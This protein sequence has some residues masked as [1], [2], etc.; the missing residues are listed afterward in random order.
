[1]YGSI[2]R[3]PIVIRLYFQNLKESTNKIR[4]NRAKIIDKIKLLN[5]KN[6]NC[7]AAAG[8]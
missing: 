3:S 1:M 8:I 5:P 4:K 7:Y 2:D 6:N